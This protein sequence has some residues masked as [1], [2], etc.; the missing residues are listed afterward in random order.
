[1]RANGRRTL[2]PL[3]KNQ[4]SAARKA[5]DA[6]ILVIAIQSKRPS[7]TAARTSIMGTTA[8]SWA[9]STPMVMRPARVRSSPT[10]SSTLMATAVLDSATTKPSRSDSP[11]GQPKNLDNTSMTAVEAPI[12]K[13]VAVTARRH[14]RR[15]TRRDSSMPTT[16]SSISTP[17]S[18]R[19]LTWSRFSTRARAEG[20]KST[21]ARM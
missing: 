6:A 1:M 13:R 17:S 18:A 10:F 4:I 9:T 20:P 12:W 2:R 21:P 3:L 14:S 16:K 8:R 11:S 15:K 19:T 7:A 5:T